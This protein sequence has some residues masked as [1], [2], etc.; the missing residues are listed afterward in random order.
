MFD[1]LPALW[2]RTSR[3]S[4]MAGTVAT[5]LGAL[6]ARTPRDASATAV[7]TVAQETSDGQG[8]ALL[9]LASSI[10]GSLTETHYTHDSYINALQGIYDTDCSGFVDYLLRQSAP[11]QYQLVPK[12]PGFTRP[13]AYMYGQF[14]RHL[15]MGV[16]EPG[17]I[18]A[19]DLLPIE[20]YHDTGHCMIVAG[21]PVPVSASVV[22]LTVI[23]SSALRHYS[24][25][26]PRGT[27]GVGSGAIHFQLSDDG[28]PLAFQFDAGE[29]FHQTPISMG[30]LG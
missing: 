23:D 26:R 28:R 14:F 22:S 25:S 9:D 15:A 13:R 1:H 12:E 19:W 16:Q 27:S 21:P 2:H 8:Q 10:V 20:Q 3:R 30:R 24:D 7:A 17:D 29:E 18:L 6:L 5:G 11:S 4:L